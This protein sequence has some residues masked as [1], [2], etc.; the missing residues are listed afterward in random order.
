[1]DSERWQKIEEVFGAAMEMRPEDRPTFL[2]DAC[3]GDPSLEDEVRSLIAA[4]ETADDY[5][6]HLAS[7]SGGLP[8]APLTRALGRKTNW[9]LPPRRT[10]GP[11]G[12]GGGLPG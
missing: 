12:D 2:A 3:S 1:M 7:E 4:S 8:G 6:S 11:R 9:E 5:F 10:P